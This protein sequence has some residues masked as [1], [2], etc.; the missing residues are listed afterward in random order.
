MNEFMSVCLCGVLGCLSG[1]KEDNVRNTLSSRSEL[2]NIILYIRN[3][4]FLDNE[5]RRVEREK[6][7]RYLSL[8]HRT[9]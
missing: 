6:H 4:S 3:Q 2:V 5:S 9:A 1:N 8:L 7:S